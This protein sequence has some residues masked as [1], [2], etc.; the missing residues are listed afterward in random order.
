MKEQKM[1]KIAIAAMS[2]ISMASLGISPGLAAIA[3]AYPNVGENS[4]ALLI[5]L[6]TILVMIVSLFVAKLNQFLSKK[7]LALLGI[8]LVVV[9]GIIPYFVDDLILILVTRAILG[10]G[11]GL[12]NPIAASLPMDHYPE[13]KDRDQALGLQSAFSGG[14]AILFTLVGGYLANLG[15]KNSFLVYLVPIAMLIVVWITLPDLG[16]VRVEK[17]GKII[18]EK[19]G[20]I[21]TSFIFIYMALFNTLS[22]NVSYLVAN[23][24]KG[25][26][27]SGYVTSAFSLLAFLGGLIFAFVAK[28]FQRFTL[29]FG[30][31]LSAIGLI[32]MGITT[33]IPIMIVGA[34][35]C[36]MGMCTVMP[37]C[38]GR[39]SARSSA[40][41]ATFAISLFM[42]G[43]SIGQAATPYVVSALSALGG[44]NIPS[45]YMI[46][47]IALAILTILNIVANLK[48]QA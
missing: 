12:V 11:V 4:I 45:Y 29:S 23:A 10:I 22:L 33:A 17:G 24:G 9:G 2:L 31:A 43:S 27:E 39:I 8:T 3:A 5:T 6:P 34:A 30:L 47:G 44:G 48:T 36:G 7:K 40:G 28:T 26:L 37:S 19:T 35:I 25:A 32:I 38:I 18:L 20:V 21:Y 13:G 16:T 46:P 1:P 15:W 42:A 14:S 41:A